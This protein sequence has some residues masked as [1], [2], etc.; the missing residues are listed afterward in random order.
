M[1]YMRYCLLICM[2]YITNQ[3]FAQTSNL[4]NYTPLESNQQAKT[5]AVTTINNKYKSILQSLPDEYRDKYKEVYKEMQK[6]MLTE[7]EKD[8]FLFNDDIQKFFDGILA[9]IK[10]GNPTLS[11]SDLKFFVSKDYAPNAQASLDGTIAFNLSLLANCENESQVAFILCHELAHNQL[12]H[13]H[14]SVKKS[15][16]ALY[17]KQAQ[18][19]MKEIAKSEYNSYEKAEAY[20]K[21]V[22][23]SNH[24]HT[25]DYEEEADSMALRYLLNTRFDATQSPKA[26]LMLDNIDSLMFTPNFDLAKTFNTPQYPFKN[27]WIEEEETMFGKGKRVFDSKWDEDS[28][29]THPSCKKRA[30]TT[31]ASLSSY[32]NKDKKVNPILSDAYSDILIKAEFENLIA[33]YDAD[34]VDYCLF[35]T[36]KSLKKYPNNVFLHALVGECFN[37]LY[38]AQ[39]NHTF[40]KIVSIPSSNLPK[41]YLPFLRFLNNLSLKDISFIGFNY[42]NGLDKSYLQ[43]EYMLYNMATAAKNADQKEALNT[44][45]SL[46]LKSFPKGKSREEIS[47]Y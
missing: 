46:Y 44:Y 37:T 23:F 39:K 17:S 6:E 4:K 31:T 40:S 9:E 34:K 33:I 35:Q 16:D 20:L 18:K 36:L 14:K 2:I 43:D 5:N 13:A 10:R 45:K 26:L 27:N 22:V 3:T 12:K 8:A 24:R 21:T 15:F 25:R 7:I 1:H 19:A 41:N 47:K 11:I 30:A 32:V 28:L 29:K 38:D 42:L